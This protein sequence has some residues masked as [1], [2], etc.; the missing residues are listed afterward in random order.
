MAKK[1]ELTEIEQI[2]KDLKFN[3][4][5]AKALEEYD[6]MYGN[7]KELVKNKTVFQIGCNLRSKSLMRLFFQE[8]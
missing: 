3:K 8:V 4:N 7:A 5:Q 6:F 1:K 2:V